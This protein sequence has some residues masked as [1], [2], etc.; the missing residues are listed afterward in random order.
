MEN[1][2]YIAKL[3]IL[4]GNYILLEGW[5]LPTLTLVC[6]RHS[7]RKVQSGTLLSVDDRTGVYRQVTALPCA[8]SELLL[9]IALRPADRFSLGCYL[10]LGRRRSQCGDRNPQLSGTRPVTRV[11]RYIDSLCSVTTRPAAGTGRLFG[12]TLVLALLN[13]F[14]GMKD[15]T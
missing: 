6:S 7:M 15:S 4:N 12:I 9:L 10:C 8:V 2:R 3:F 5:A 11:N 14:K 1:I 13:C